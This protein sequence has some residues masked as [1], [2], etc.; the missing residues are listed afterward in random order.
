VASAD[1]LGLAGKRVLVTGVANRRSIAW[2]VHR[3]LVEVGA[4]PVHVVRDEATRDATARLLEGCDVHVC[5]VERQAE[6]DALAA[7]LSADG[8]RLAGLLHSIAFANYAG[9]V[10]PFHE[11]ER[12]DFLQA[13]DVSCYSLVALCR[14][15]APCLEGGASVVTLSISHTHLAA[16][17]YGYMAPVKAALDAAVVFL[18][19]SLAQ[20]EGRGVRVNAV[21]AGP[22]KT[23]ASAGIPGYLDN[24]L[25]AEQA[26]LRH[27]ALRTEEAADAALWLLSPRSSGVNA[28][29]LVVD[30]GMG[31]NFFDSEIVRRATAP[32]GGA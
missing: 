11:T 31:V 27:A 10:R 3:G 30:A 8:V 15:L 18:A 19:K 23:T 29:G 12:A 20:H 16:E 2:H 4:V 13:V 6:I 24:Y 17:S 5:D 32:E 1:W 14:A 28:Q 7:R 25:F 21:K 9:G 22:L 26:T